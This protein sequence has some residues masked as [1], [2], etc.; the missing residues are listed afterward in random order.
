MGKGNKAILYVAPCGSGKTKVFSHF[1]SLIAAK[2]NRVWILTHREELCTQV[3]DTLTEFGVPHSFIQSGQYLDYKPLAH[4][5]S[6]QTLVRRMDKISIKPTVLI[7]DESHHSCSAS[8]KKIFS[9]FSEAWRIGV[10]ATPERLDGKG[11][12]DIFQD[13]IIGPTMAQL[14][15]EGFLSPYKLYAPPLV[16]TSKLHTRMG[17]FAINE[18]NAATDKP[19][20][21]GNAIVHYRKYADGL[22]AVVYCC[23]IEHAR[24]TAEQFCQAGYQAASIDGNMDGGMRKEFVRNFREGKIQVL[25]S[26]EI[27]SEGFDLPAIQCAIF[28][29]PTKSLAMWI[30]MSGRALRIME[31]KKEAILLDHVG[32]ALRLGFPDD[33]RDWSLH[34]ATRREGEKSASVR[35]CP[36]CLRAIRPGVEVC[37][38]CGHVFK[39]QSREVG[40]VDGEL[41]EAA[42]DTPLPI[43]NEFFKE[44]NVKEIHDWFIRTRK[45]TDAKAWRFAYFI[46]QQRQKA[47]LRAVAER[48]GYAVFINQNPK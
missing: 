34:G 36:K 44:M 19:K 21:T 4:V 30:Q 12:G 14:I 31:G 45:T 5:C 35:V 10:T 1:A 26:C 8:Y 42:P 7:I 43:K 32:N 24:H 47:K 41:V 48:R 28:L 29:R 3:S 6:V 23:S 13:M 38:E 40:H 16:D 46:N 2:K 17:D 9:H 18:A 25:T 27:I 22:R 37:P 39:V 33:D 15:A 11:L 20:I